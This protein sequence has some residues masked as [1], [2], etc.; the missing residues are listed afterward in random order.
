MPIENNILG[1]ALSIIGCFFMW[2][3]IDIY[4]I[5]RSVLKLDKRRYMNFINAD[6]IF[7]DE[8]EK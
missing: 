1:E 8:Q 4:A 2:E 3:A 7:I 6:I 5:Q